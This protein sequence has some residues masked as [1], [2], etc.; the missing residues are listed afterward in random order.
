MFKTCCFISVSEEP[1]LTGLER[2]QL[3]YNFN[4]ILFYLTFAKGVKKYL[5]PFC[6]EM[7]DVANRTTNTIAAYDASVRSVLALPKGKREYLPFAFYLDKRFDATKEISPKNATLRL[8]YQKMIDLSDY[9]VFYFDKKRVSEDEKD[10]FAYAKKSNKT[11]L[12]M[13]PSKNVSA[14]FK[15]IDRPAT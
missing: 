15:L 10:L 2:E 11:A 5:F 13:F 9:C 8:Y 6:G 12:N 3:E 14:L 1:F 4:G 7:P